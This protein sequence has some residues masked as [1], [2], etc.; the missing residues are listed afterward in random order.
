MDNKKCN[1]LVPLHSYSE[2]DN[3]M[4]VLQNQL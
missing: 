1:L 4:P 3:R 2:E